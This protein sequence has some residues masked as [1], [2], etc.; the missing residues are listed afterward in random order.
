MESDSSIQT[1]PI[2]M[3]QHK[4]IIIRSNSYINPSSIPHN[5]SRAN[6]SRGSQLSQSRGSLSQSR[7]SF[8][9]SRESFT[10]SRGSFSQSRVN[11]QQYNSGGSGLNRSV[12]NSAAFLHNMSSSSNVLNTSTGDIP[13]NATL[14][15]LSL[16]CI[17]C[18]N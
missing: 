15:N 6:N 3:D 2:T 14:R 7:D 12:S 16:S 10:K 17:Q 13:Q 9:Q 8:T 11:V 1:L 5:G 18:R 4:R